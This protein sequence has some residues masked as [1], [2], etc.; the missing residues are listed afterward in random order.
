MNIFASAVVTGT[1][2]LA[3]RAFATADLDWRDSLLTR[4]LVTNK[5]QVEATINH[6]RMRVN[7]AQLTR[8]SALVQS[9]KTRASIVPR[10]KRYDM[11]LRVLKRP[12]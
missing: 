8:I 10:A 9:Q 11:D 1:A 6:T 2:G 7:R 3:D 5:L 12:I 4:D